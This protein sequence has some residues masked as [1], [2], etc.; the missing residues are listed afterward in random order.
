MSHHE[1]LRILAFI[2]DGAPDIIELLTHQ[3]YPKVSN[4]D[5]ISQIDHLATAGQHRIVTDQLQDFESY[6]AMRH[7]FP[8]E[9][10]LIAITDKTTA[11]T[12]RAE[13]SDIPQ[14]WDELENLHE[15]DL[16]LQA[17]DYLEALTSDDTWHSR[18]NELIEKHHFTR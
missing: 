16:I 5:M 10:T 11:D 4:D 18:L 13:K 3:G 7:A 2:G 14:N 15:T 1:N 6:K 12:L 9:L 8:G 17:D